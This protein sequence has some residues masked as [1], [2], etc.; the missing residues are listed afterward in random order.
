M[1]VVERLISSA[2]FF[3][4]LRGRPLHLMIND[5][6]TSLVRNA[7]WL[8]SSRVFCRAACAP[9]GAQQ[10]RHCRRQAVPYAPT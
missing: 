7:P 1:K 3:F 4:S 9:G 2:V 5:G 8:L 10:G 6:C